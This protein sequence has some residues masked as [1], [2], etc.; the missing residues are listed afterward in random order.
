MDILAKAFLSY[1]HADNAREGGRILRLAEHLRNEFELL[2]GSTIEI[3]TD[4]AEILWGQDFRQRLDEALQET[5]FFIPVL[6]P[7]YFIR[8]ECRKEMNQFVASASGLG[9]NELLLSLRYI[10]VP[11]LREESVDDLK[12]VAARMQFE[13]WDQ[14]RLVDEHSTEHRLAVNRLAARLVQLT[15]DLE[16]GTG[17]VGGGGASLGSALVTIPSPNS[18]SNE[19]IVLSPSKNRE[20]REANPSSAASE[21]TDGRSRRDHDHAAEAV[22]ETTR[23]SEDDE[24]GLVD[25]VAEVEPA[26]AAWGATLT[27]MPEATQAF[28]EK[29]AAATSKM[30]AA[31][32][33]PNSFALKVQV[34]RE[35]ARDVEPDLALIESLSKEYTT[36]LLRLDPSIRAL[37]ELAALGSDDESRP[38]VAELSNSIGK[39][40]EAARSAMDST[41]FAADAARA[42]AKLS[43]DLRPVLRRFETAMRN[44]VDGFTF[45]EAWDTLRPSAA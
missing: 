31:N 42:N 17:A 5:T 3:F 38:V 37:F 40:I 24:P 41:T 26:M 23:H 30:E 14:L 29:F 7:T 12:S 1:A 16:G 18:R 35:L 32:S 2:T 21:K 39:L 43:K 33:K 44:I 13:P 6:T 9:L 34:A 28:N 10:P 25:L 45:I 36:S 11:D 15:Q 22:E 20:D 27:K 4:N 19:H 8:E